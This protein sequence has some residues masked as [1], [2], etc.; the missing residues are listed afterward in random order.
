MK[1][2][3]CKIGDWVVYSWRGQEYIM[4]ILAIFEDN[5]IGIHGGDLTARIRIDPKSIRP[6]TIQDAKVGDVLYS[7]EGLGV[8][9]I[10]IVGGWEQ[11]EGIGK[12][13]CSPV[14]YRVKDDEIVAGG[15][16]AIWWEGVKDPHYP[17]TDEQ[18]MLLFSKMEKAGYKWNEV[19]QKL[20]EIVPKKRIYIS[21]AINH[22]N[23][24]E[25]FKAFEQVEK[26]LVEQGH[27]V[28][29]PMKNGLPSDSTTSQ[30]MRRDLSELTREDEPYTTI[31]MMKG[32]NH[33]AGCWDEFHDALAI[34]LEVIIEQI[35][36]PVK[37][38]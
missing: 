28:F 1:K 35:G 6:W 3:D 2:E 9:A 36:T 14:L 18:R 34:G 24:E 7:P 26:M 5:T 16:G 13:L 21:G 27:E 29:N 23:I 30:H 38:E 19:E 12:T 37:F 32:W 15:L 22:L 33:S 4:Q 25:R 10:C 11:I 8:E 20:E 17:A 31:Y